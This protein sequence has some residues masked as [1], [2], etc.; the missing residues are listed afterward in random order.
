[1]ICFFLTSSSQAWGPAAATLSGLQHFSEHT[2]SWFSAENSPSKTGNCILVTLVSYAVR[3]AQESV[4]D[5][6]CPSLRK[7]W[8]ERGCG[9]WG[10][11]TGRLSHSWWQ[12]QGIGLALSWPSP[13][14]LVS[15]ENKEHNENI[16]TWPL[17]NVN[18]RRN[19]FKWKFSCPEEFNRN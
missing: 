13:T 2:G 9:R 4:E 1:M 16:S 18:Y 5:R 10:G 17:N 19:Q 11:G 7:A 15:H 14:H 3:W 12:Q 6:V 8:F